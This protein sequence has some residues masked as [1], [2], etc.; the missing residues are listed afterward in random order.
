MHG[1]MRRREATP[2]QSATPRGPR[3]P[4]AD[5]TKRQPQRRG[6]FTA[7]IGSGCVQTSRSTRQAGPDVTCRFRERL[8][9]VGLS[10]SAEPLRLTAGMSRA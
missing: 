7:S 3:K 9:C 8:S 2:D 5:P 6:C 1:S 4:P 10:A